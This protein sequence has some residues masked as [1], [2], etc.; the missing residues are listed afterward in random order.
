MYS[1]I[2]VPTDGGP[3]VETVLEHTTDIADADGT[4]VHVLYVIDDGA[5]LTLKDDMK[6]EVLEDLRSEGERAVS[7][8]AEDLDADGF[9]VETA[10]RRGSP[11]ET[12][13]SYVEDAG[14]ELVTMGTQADKY[15]ENMLGSTSQKVVTKSPAPVLTVNVAEE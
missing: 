5:F 10:I 8:V 14:I 3:S 6:T 7:E 9:E 15:T 4:T 1:D 11:A 2:L 12:I 13:V